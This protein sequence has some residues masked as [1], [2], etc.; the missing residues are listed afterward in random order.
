MQRLL[1]SIGR[2]AVLVASAGCSNG[3][4]AET[5]EAMTSTGAADETSAAT[6]GEGV[7]ASLCEQACEHLVTCGDDVLA[8]TQADCVAQCEASASQDTPDC[9]AAAKD[10]YGCLRDTPCAEIQPLASGSCKLADADYVISCVGCP[11]TLVFANI[12]QC[13]AD[14]ACA[15]T[16]AVSFSCDGGLCR[17]ELDGIEYRS[18]AEADACEDGSAAI[19]AAATRCCGVP[20]VDG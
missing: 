17:C 1:R 8:P 12:G 14:V 18:C 11:A 10:L 5:E 9:N 20:F 15:D 2:L 7:S 16:F 19:F 6:T 4:A 3:P 13:S